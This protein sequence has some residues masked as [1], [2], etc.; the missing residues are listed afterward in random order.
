MDIINLEM[1]SN[2]IYL[3]TYLGDLYLPIRTIIL[4]GIIVITLRSIKLFK[5]RK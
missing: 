4:V 5:A 3:T 1:D 2:S